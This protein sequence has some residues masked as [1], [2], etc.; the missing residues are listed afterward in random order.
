M[1]AGRQFRF[2]NLISKVFY[3][4][5]SR[6]IREREKLKCDQFCETSL[7][8]SNLVNAT[9][10]IYF[11]LGLRVKCVLVSI[12]FLL[13]VVIE[14]SRFHSSKNVTDVIPEFFKI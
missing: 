13:L 2:D 8:C 14:V 12:K 3:L 11:W 1:G 6:Y 7:T 5:R 4:S 10:A 9:F